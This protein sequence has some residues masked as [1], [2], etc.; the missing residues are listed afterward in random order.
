[1]D[2]NIQEVFQQCLERLEEGRSLEECLAQ[3]PEEAGEL[4]PLL[5]TALT[6]RG[7]FALG[8][9]TA[10][11]ARL[12][13]RVMGEWD[14]RHQRR[15]WPQPWTFLPVPQFSLRAA[16]VAAS[17]VLAVALSGAGT[18]AAA[19]GAVPGDRLYPVKELREEAQLW[20]AWSPEAKV[21]MYTHLVKQRAREVQELAAQE[22]VRSQAISQALDRMNRH[23]AALNAVVEENA[24]RQ[25]LDP[26]AVDAGFLEALQH[27]AQG[28]QSAQIALEE[29][30]AEAPSKSQPGLGEALD[31]IQRAQERVRA[32]AA[33]AGQA[34]SESDR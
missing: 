5:Q 29:T 7:Q 33:A 3:F 25:R 8:I 30:L 19:G 34:G 16:T 26:T 14:R 20:F 18:V 24:R 32:A 23:L 1:M 13:N 2:D 12:R 10:A 17:L 21:E 4:E 15:R 6:A 28:Q 27:S 31:A 9:S 22:E 11:R